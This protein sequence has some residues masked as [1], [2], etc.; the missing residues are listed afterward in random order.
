LYWQ[1]K[2]FIAIYSFATLATYQVMMMSLFRVMI[3][4]L[5]TEFAFINTAGFFQYVQRAI[6]GRFIDSGHFY[7][8]VVDNFTGGNMTPGIM[9]DIRD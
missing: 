5:V 1:E 4:K 3:D 6:D 2:V 7:L 8:N 9:Y